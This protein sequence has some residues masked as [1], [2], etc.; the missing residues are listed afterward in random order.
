MKINGLIQESG[1]K[2]L[3]IDDDEAKV[4]VVFGAPWAN[5]KNYMPEIPEKIQDMEGA[6]FAQIRFGGINRGGW[7][8]IDSN[9]STEDRRVTIVHELMHAA[10]VPNHNTLDPN[11]ALYQWRGTRSTS[12]VFSGSDQLVLRFLYNV[13]ESADTEEEIRRGVFEHWDTLP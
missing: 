12:L 2:F 7:S 4:K 13:L 6:G 8:F 1:I 10:G 11:S 5:G 3:L 9:Q